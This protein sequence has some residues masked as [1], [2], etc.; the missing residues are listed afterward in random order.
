MLTNLK[1]Q[2]YG[3][4][5]RYSSHVWKV[6]E[7]IPEGL[8]CVGVTLLFA[9]FFYRS[10]WAVIPMSL[11]GILL[12][13][14]DNEK[15]IQKDKRLLV[16]QFCDC[17][18]SADTAMRAGYSV[19]NA[20]LASIPDMQLMHGEDSFI[21]RELERMRRGIV[22]NIAIEELFYDFG[23]RS[24][25]PQIQ[26]FADVLSIAK[27]NGGNIPEMIRL[28]AEC[29]RHKVEAEE[30]IDTLIAGKRLEQMIMNIMPFGITLYL[31]YSNPGYFDIL[32][33][34]IQ[35]I[36]IMSGCLA[37]YLT[38]YYLSERI[39]RQITETGV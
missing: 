8:K 27:R 17:I 5:R 24:T 23:K 20:F 2:E 13:K 7:L 4:G 39:L 6:K 31:E 19:E 30:E 34:N 18:H 9:W 10:L 15:M 33:H 1:K 16:M 11:A 12:W 21:C 22:I 36:G 26:E 38:A 3:K 32:F 37:A 35:G 14:Q 25:I 28:N 29:I